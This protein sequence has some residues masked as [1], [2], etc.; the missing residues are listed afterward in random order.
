VKSVANITRQDA[1]EFLP[2]AARIPIAPEVQEFGLA[3]ANEALVLLKQ[4][5]IRGAAVLRTG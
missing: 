5:K 4:G 2:L 1:A 3:E